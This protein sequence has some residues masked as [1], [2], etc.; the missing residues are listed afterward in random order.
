M[1]VEPIVHQRVKPLETNHRCPPRVS[2]S[3]NSVTH[4]FFLFIFLP[5]H[6]IHIIIII[7]I[8]FISPTSANQ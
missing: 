6:S 4:N 3:P 2:W 8:F 1:G 5:T 7:I